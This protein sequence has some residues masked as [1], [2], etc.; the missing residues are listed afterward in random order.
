L[1]D[2]KVKGP[3]NTE[4]ITPPHTIPPWQGDTREKQYATRI[5]TNP[6]RRGITKGEAADEHRT[7]TTQISQENE[8]IITYTNGSMKEK[9]Q[10]NWTGA[11]WVVYWKGEECQNLA[12]PVDIS[13]SMPAASNRNFV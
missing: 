2:V 7:R 11:G 6:A 8:Y 5:S 3:E 4:K 10:E 1:I 12:F 13:S 9:E